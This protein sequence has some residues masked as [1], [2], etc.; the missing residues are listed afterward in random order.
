MIDCYDPR[1]SIEGQGE[2]LVLVPGL[3]GA[4]ELFYRQLPSLRQA[5]RV[6]TY[7][8]RDD[9]PAL[10][11]LADD[12]ARVIEHVAPAE[13]RAIIVGESFGGT[14]A[15]TL[16][17]MHPERVS[18]LVILNSFPYWDAQVRLRLAIAGLTVVP[19]N[20]VSLMRQLA[21]SRLHSRHTNHAE[22]KRFIGL[23]ARA[24]RRGYVNRLKLLQDYDVRHR[25]HEVCH[26]T[27]FLAAEADHLVPAV[28]QA[29]YMSDRVPASRV[30]VLEGHG[31]ICLIAPNLE[32]ATILADWRAGT[33]STEA[34]AG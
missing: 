11:V 22:V 5:Y 31:H 34:L 19:W 23:T 15:L 3:N 4:G 18:A 2:P 24:T 21:A 9:A 30:R 29:R 26:P 27:L 16:A 1:V 20:A 10:D 32:L 33:P 17:L 6:A 8:L 7:S 12:L 25:L 13:R 14:V 28:A